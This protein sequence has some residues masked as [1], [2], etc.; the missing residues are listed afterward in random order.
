MVALDV[1]YGQLEHLGLQPPADDEGRAELAGGFGGGGRIFEHLPIA[2]TEGQRWLPYFTTPHDT[3]LASASATY[4]CTHH[5][6][7]RLDELREALLRAYSSD[8]CSVVEAMVPKTSARDQQRELLRR[9]GETLA[10]EG[11]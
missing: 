2:E 10:A 3:D 11:S 6:V 7:T 9:V 1:G 4:G 8:G 5:R